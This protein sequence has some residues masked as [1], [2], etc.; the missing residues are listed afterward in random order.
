MTQFLVLTGPMPDI[1]LFLPDAQV[2]ALADAHDT[3]RVTAEKFLTNTQCETSWMLRGGQTGEPADYMCGHIGFEMVVEEKDFSETLLGR[4]LQN[5][6]QSEG[7]EQLTFW[8]DI[9]NKPMKDFMTYAHLASYLKDNMEYDA[10]YK[11]EAEEKK[12]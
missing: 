9:G 8:Y 11:K 4:F 10:I 3:V 2:I 12:G 5:Y 6:I 1:Q 7:F